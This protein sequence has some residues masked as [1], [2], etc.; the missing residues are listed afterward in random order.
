MGRDIHIHSIHSR[1][2]CFVVMFLVVEFYIY[3]LLM[4]HKYVLLRDTH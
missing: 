3:H 1:Y 4:I 2:L